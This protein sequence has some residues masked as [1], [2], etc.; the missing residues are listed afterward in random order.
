MI[1][2]TRPHWRLTIIVEKEDLNKFNEILENELNDSRIQIIKNQ[3]RKLAG[4][5]NTGMK[6]AQTDFVAILLSDDMWANNAVEVLSG[7]ITQFPDVDFFHSSRII[8]DENDSPISPIYL[9]KEQFSV[10]DFKSGSPVKHLLCW[11]KD[12]ALSVGGLDESLNSVGPDDYDFPWTMAEHGATFKAVKECLYIYRD[13]R[14]CFRLTT[15]LPLSVHKK[16]IETIF[17]KH[18]VDTGT[19][20]K[21][22]A[23]AE[24]TYLRKCLY[25][26]KFERWIKELL[27]YDAKRGWRGVYKKYV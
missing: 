16:E 12:K 17:R 4:A 26:S 11:R 13:H 27:G 3:G 20:R 10:D 18:G 23:R 14:N 1:N 25:R 21:K 5:I 15:H 8:V 24:K 9:S 6:L 2:Q 22:I 19:I 7:Y